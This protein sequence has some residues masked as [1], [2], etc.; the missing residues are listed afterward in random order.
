MSVSVSK[1]VYTF[2][3]SKVPIID[4]R[5]TFHFEER[6]NNVITA[7]SGWG[8][9]TLFRLMSGW[10]HEEEKVDVSMTGATPS[11]FFFIGNHQ[12][13]LPWKKVSQNVSMYTGLPPTSLKLMKALEDLALPVGTLDKFPYQLSLGMYKRVELLSAIY[14]RSDVLI[15]DEYFA[16]LDSEARMA[17]QRL[18]ESKRDKTIIMSTH[19]IDTLPFEQVR[20]FNLSRNETTGTIVSVEEC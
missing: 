11:S 9:T 3:D 7:P 8:K 4:I 16:S 10:F 19:S 12:T 5:N 17:S 6:D 2:P 18:I 14:S 15:L 20:V 1:A 13:M